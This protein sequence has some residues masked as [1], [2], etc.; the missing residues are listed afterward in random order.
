MRQKLVRRHP[1]VFDDV[2][3]GDADEVKRN[4]DRINAGEAG[5][6]ATGSAL[7]GVPDGMPALQKAA[8][9]QNRAAKVGFDW[10]RAEQVVPVVAGELA[11]LE[12]ALSGSG[13]IE[14]ELGDV[15]FSV[16]NLSRHLGIDPEIALTRATATFT[17]RFRRMETEGPLDG[18][19]L[20]E[21]NER[22]ERAKTG[23]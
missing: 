13:D 20:D 9:T 4:W 16:V 12:A 21:L 10:E 17:T 19:G 22:W 8:K 11:E 2:V 5:R 1:H 6:E 23:P 14:A 15:L 7:D 3:V 18:L